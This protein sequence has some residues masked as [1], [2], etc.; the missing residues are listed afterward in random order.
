M[1]RRVFLIFIM[2]FVCGYCA[3]T[4][5]LAEPN[6]AE[7]LKH[8][9]RN[10]DGVV[11]KK[12]IR[13]EKKWED[14]H[15]WRHGKAQVSNAVE[16]KYDANND[17]W[18]EEAEVRQLLKDKYEMVKT[19]GKAKVD[20]PLEAAYDANNDGILDKTEAERMLSDAQ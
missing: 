10:K 20:T 11:D 15:A 3:V 17:G 4:A 14:T 9:D 6:K 5:I 7:K 1:P 16:R 12:E 13:M 18:L 8:A 19:G 2:L